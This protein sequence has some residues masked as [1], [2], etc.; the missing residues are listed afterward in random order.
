MGVYEVIIISSKIIERVDENINLNIYKV[1]F[2]TSDSVH[3]L[4]QLK[5]INYLLIQT[6]VLN[7][8]ECR[9]YNIISADLKMTDAQE[10]MTTIHFA[11]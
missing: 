3:D 2:N 10:V 6:M 9:T 8:G 4:N 1:I 5:F 11:F 7:V